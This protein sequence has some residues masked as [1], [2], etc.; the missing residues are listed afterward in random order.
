MGIETGDPV[1]RLKTG[2][3]TAFRDERSAHSHEQ[4]H[5]RASTERLQKACFRD[6]YALV[7]TLDPVSE[8]AAAEARPISLE[9]NL[10]KTLTVMTGPRA[11]ARGEC[12]GRS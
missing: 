12:T 10:L 6:L 2:P 11:P 3:E 8:S 9:N 1:A 7:E 4:K 5:A